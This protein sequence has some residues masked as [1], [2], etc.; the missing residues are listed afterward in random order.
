MERITVR[1]SKA[2][3]QQMDKLIEELE[4]FPN[5]S[6]LIRYAVTLFISQYIPP[7]TQYDELELG[8]VAKIQNGRGRR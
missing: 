7:R 4:L 2:Q 5:K 8:R 1:F 3:I 6:E